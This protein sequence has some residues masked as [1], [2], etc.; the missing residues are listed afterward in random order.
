MRCL[1]RLTIGGAGWRKEFV[2]RPTKRPGYCR[3][4]NALR[5]AGTATER[6]SRWE[7]AT[8]EMSTRP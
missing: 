7:V 5:W 6:E 8:L 4:S 1:Q 3:A 2:G